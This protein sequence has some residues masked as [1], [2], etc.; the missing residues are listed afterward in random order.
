MSLGPTEVAVRVG[1]NIVKTVSECTAQG[2]KTFKNMTESPGIPPESLR[3]PFGN[4]LETF[5]K[6]DEKLAEIGWNLTTSSTNQWL[7]RKIC[8]AWLPQGSTRHFHTKRASVQVSNKGRAFAKSWS[9]ITNFTTHLDSQKIPGWIGN[10]LASQL[11]V[12][13]WR[14]NTSVSVKSLFEKLLPKPCGPKADLF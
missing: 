13:S 11:P 1:R 8:C 10:W 5:G 2:T 4:P 12:P 14:E 6:P 9:V 3:N 7:E